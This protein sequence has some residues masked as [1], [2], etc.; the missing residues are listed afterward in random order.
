MY[1]EYHFRSLVK[2]STFVS[3]GLA[4]TMPASCKPFI[5]TYYVTFSDENRFVTGSK[6][7]H[8]TIWTNSSQQSKKV[9]NNSEQF[10]NATLVKYRNNRIYAIGYR[11]ATL[12]IMDLSLG[13]I[14]VVPHKFENPIRLLVASSKYIAVGEFAGNVSVFDDKENLVLVSLKIG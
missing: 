8:V 14:K 12:T 3:R 5:V 1:S 13:L 4:F 7:G 6:D 11:E 2:K 9:F 10:K